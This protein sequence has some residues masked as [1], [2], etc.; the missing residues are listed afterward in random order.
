MSEDFSKKVSELMNEDE[1]DE[2]IDDVAH[3]WN[4]QQAV[5][6]AHNH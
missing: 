3:N 4:N 2:D 1:D 5:A 6:K